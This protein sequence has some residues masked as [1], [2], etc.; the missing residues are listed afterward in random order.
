M[1]LPEAGTWC[2]LE[3][4]AWLDHGKRVLV[5][6]WHEPIRT[7]VNV[8]LPPTPRRPTHGP[9][10]RTEARRFRAEAERQGVQLGRPT[11]RYLREV[12]QGRVPLQ[13]S[14]VRAIEA[15]VTRRLAERERQRRPM[16]VEFGPSLRVLWRPPS[17]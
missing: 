11:R 16:R 5:W 1:G 6:G 14:K 8:E 3:V 10:A 2:G 12:I 9:R 7:T 4:Q 13:W 15:Y 17:V